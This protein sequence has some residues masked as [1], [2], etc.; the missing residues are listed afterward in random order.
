MIDEKERERYVRER[1]REREREH[2]ETH[3]TLLNKKKEG[4]SEE[5][6]KGI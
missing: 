6:V 5:R 1:K 3:Q 2:D 4:G